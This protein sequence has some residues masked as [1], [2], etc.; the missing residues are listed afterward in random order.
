MMQTIVLQVLWQLEG[1][2]SSSSLQAED[3]PLPFPIYTP[4]LAG[5]WGQPRSQT[6]H[7]SPASLGNFLVLEHKS[8]LSAS[9][10]LFIGCSIFGSE[11][12]QVR[13]AKGLAYERCWNG[14]NNSYHLGLFYVS[15]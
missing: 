14:D 5:A 6:T 3:G 13:D 4:V 2:T 1:Q 9:F 8:R 15:M 10:C 12:A 7:T 11:A